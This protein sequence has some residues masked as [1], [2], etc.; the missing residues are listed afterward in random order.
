MSTRFYF[1]SHS[2][3]V[4]A[5]TRHPQVKYTMDY[6][7]YNGSVARTRPDVEMLPAVHRRLDFVFPIHVI[8]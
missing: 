2:L 8:S 4:S 3:H 6:F 7:Q 1:P 5:P